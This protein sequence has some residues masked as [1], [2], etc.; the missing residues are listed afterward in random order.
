M[1]EQPNVIP[2]PTFHINCVNKSLGSAS[3]KYEI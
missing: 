2:L 3:V 1:A